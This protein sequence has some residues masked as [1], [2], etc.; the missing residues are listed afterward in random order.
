[1]KM[2]DVDQP[3]FGERCDR[4]SPPPLADRDFYD[5]S[6]PKPTPLLRVRAGAPVVE[7]PDLHMMTPLG[8]RGGEIHDHRQ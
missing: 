7:L 3:L 6:S 4:P 1:M 8:Q 5:T 2:H